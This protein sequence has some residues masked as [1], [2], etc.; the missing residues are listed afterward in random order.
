MA[1]AP[2][3]KFI[4]IS[5]PV[6]PGEQVVYTTP[7]G[8]ASIVL[9]AQVANVTKNS[10]FSD[11]TCKQRRTTRLGNTR[12]IR[13]VKDAEVYP[14]DT[15]VLVE[16]RLVL[17]KTALVSDSLV[18]VSESTNA[19]IVSIQSCTYNEVTGDTTITTIGTHPFSPGDEITMS[20]L[21]FTCPPGSGIT[22]SIFPSPQ[23]P[24]TVTNVIS[25]TEF[26]TNAGVG[27]GIQ[28]THVA[29]TGLVAPLELEFTCSILENS[30]V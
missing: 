5:V 3:N 12:D 1:V 29:N 18:I 28:H 26:E 22:T 4:N 19:G 14:N 27:A 25:S 17:E 20:G 11:V 23:V 7:T 21:E 16:G 6:A 24:F 2:L 9:F 8:V 30:I 10:T 13:L 15:L